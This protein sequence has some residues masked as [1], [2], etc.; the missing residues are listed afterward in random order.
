M[1]LRNKLQLLEKELTKI[2][3]KLEDTL[4]SLRNNLDLEEKYA[5]INQK[6]LN[7]RKEFEE[8]YYSLKND[9]KLFNE[10]ILKKFKLLLEQLREIEEKGL[11]NVNTLIFRLHLIKNMFVRLGIDKECLV[12]SFQS[13]SLHYLLEDVIEI[14]NLLLEVK[15]IERKMGKNSGLLRRNIEFLKKQRTHL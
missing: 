11:D 13:K 1:N 5:L 10:R 8:K 2:N 7:L 12:N 15:S 14:E 6:I 9:F 4:L 3:K